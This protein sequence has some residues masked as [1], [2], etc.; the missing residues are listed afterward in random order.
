MSVCLL[1]CVCT[2]GYESYA[3]ILVEASMFKGVPQVCITVMS[4]Y[5]PLSPS[6]GVGDALEKG[7]KAKK[8]ISYSYV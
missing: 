4:V 5:D 1:L 7:L 8:L 6:N 2:S 3:H